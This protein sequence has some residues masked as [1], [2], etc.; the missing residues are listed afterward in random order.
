MGWPRP[1]AR[2]A[3]C[4]LLTVLRTALPI[5]GAIVAA[6]LALAGAVI[7]AIA[8][9]LDPIVFGVIP[10]DSQHREAATVLYTL[11]RWKWPAAWETD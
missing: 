1:A 9:D 5:A 2:S 11:A 7:D 4:Q 3:T 10:A 6:L 8:A